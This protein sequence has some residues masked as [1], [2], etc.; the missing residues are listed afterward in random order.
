MGHRLLTRFISKF[1]YQTI[2]TSSQADLVK[3][4]TSQLKE[5][6]PLDAYQPQF[7]PHHNLHQAKLFNSSISSP[8]TRDFNHPTHNKV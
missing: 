4:Y 8:W 7:L 6:V 5:T 2:L 1:I 3:T